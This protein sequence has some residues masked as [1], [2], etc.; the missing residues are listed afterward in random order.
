MLN[1]MYR[2]Y[3]KQQMNL[4]EYIELQE[5]L[6]NGGKLKWYERK[7]YAEYKLQEQQFQKKNKTSIASLNINK[8]I[9][10][11]YRRKNF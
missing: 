4:N 11:M 7:G 3:I 10:K 8:E 5:R 1:E 9:K 2:K 6:E